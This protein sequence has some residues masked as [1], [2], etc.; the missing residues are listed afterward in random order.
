MRKKMCARKADAVTAKACFFEGIFPEE[1]IRT[2]GGIDNGRVLSRRG[3]DRFLCM[4][5]DIP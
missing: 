2:Y 4:R 5:R 1:R 3:H